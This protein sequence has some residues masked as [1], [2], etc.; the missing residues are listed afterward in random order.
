MKPS[1]VVRK[2][3]SWVLVLILA[4]PLSAAAQD[5]Q[6]AAAKKFGQE[7][8][9]QILAP[10]ALYSDPLLA[11][12]LMA[13]TY[14]LEVVLADRW[15]RQNR[16]L[17]GEQLNDAL[18]RQPWDASVKALIPFPAVLAMM[19][20]KLDWT[21]MV[22]DAF[23]A[24][25]DAVMD[26]IQQLRQKA[27]DANNLKTTDQQQVIAEQDAIRI[28]PTNPEV[29]FVP[30]YDPWWV[31][32]PWWWPAYPPYV[33][34]PYRPGVVFAP[35]FIWFGSG[36]IVGASWGYAWG[37]WGWRQHHVFVNANRAVNINRANISRSN[38]KTTTW[39]HDPVHRRGVAYRDPVSRE[40]F[41]QVNR[42]AVENR[43]NFRG[44]ERTPGGGAISGP[45]AVV[46]SPAPAPQAT[47]PGGGSRR[48]G[49][50]GT[51]SS[52]SVPQ[53]TVS[54]PP[55]AAP[56]ALP[57]ATISRPPGQAA[58]RA[59]GERDSKPSAFTGI[60]QGQE[61]RRQSTRGAEVRSGASPG[62][63][64]AGGAVRGGPG[65]G[66]PGGSGSGGV[67]GGSGGGGNRGGSGSGSRGG[68]R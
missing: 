52:P 41:G 58:G 27:Y 61:V 19:S 32:G 40:R 29:V 25:E 16:D 63:S 30:V 14:P 3:V 5:G 20:E 53:A 64:T 24:Q 38:I 54:R 43:R 2:T 50:P 37:H 49:P 66:A 51:I 11:Q 42:D 34:Y 1:R 33:V 13:A 12:V 21:R 55:A 6:Q 4:L 10:I 18:D 47:A 36:F 15:V 17:Q 26:T 56:S 62:G 46:R 67:R 60:G 48:S 9:D 7:Q 31:Y 44:F 39:A 35:G 28:E 68:H 23:L 45:S 65:G 8:L 22:G 59:G 57:Q